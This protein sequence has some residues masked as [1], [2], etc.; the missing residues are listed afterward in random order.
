MRV[1]YNQEQIKAII[2]HRYPM[3]LVDN[4]IEISETAE[5]N[6]Y[7]VGEKLAAPTD[8]YFAGHFP[9]YP[10][11]PGVLIIEALAQTGL[12]AVLSQ[13]EHKGKLGMFTGIDKAKFRRQV[14][15]GDTMRLYVEMIKLKDFHGKLLGSA[16]I[17]AT[18]EGEV[19]A[20]AEMSFIVMDVEK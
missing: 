19:A 4:I 1:I 20:S 18:V 8:P 9:E 3:L 14:L 6:I 2:P 7:I 10:V 5:G 15:P 16:R 12:V 11:M 13:P 17:E